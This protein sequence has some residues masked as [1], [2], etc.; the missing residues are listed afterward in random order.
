MAIAVLFGV[1]AILL[2]MGAP[3]AVAMLTASIVDIILFGMPALI[4]AERLT[5]S[6]NSFPLLAI[7]F[8]IL[9]GVI[10]N[11]GGLTQRLLD[12]SRAWVGHF[13]GG[14]A[15]V[16]VLSSIFFSGISGSASADAAAIGSMLIPTMKRE[17]YSS[18]FA[19]GV[20]AASATI[21]PIIP[22]SIVLV[23]Y[24]SMTNLSIG[25]LFLGGI[26][27]GLMIGIGL[28]LVVAVMARRHGYPRSERLSY[29]QRLAVTMRAVPALLAP[30]IIVGGILGGLYTATEAGVIACLYALVVGLV[31]Y[32]ELR[33]RDLGSLLIDAAEQ[34]AIPVFV[35]AS[36]SIFGWLLTIHGFGRMVIGFMDVLDLGPLG[37]L[38]FL[39]VVLTIIGLFVEGLAALI[40]FVPL[41][42]PLI[43]AF[44]LDSIHVALIMV[45]TILIGTV[46]PPVG[47]QLYIAAT[48]GRCPI[49]QVVIWPFVGVML[50]VVVAIVLFP[51]LVT[52]L[53]RI[54]GLA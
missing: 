47:L 28:M 37:V 14:T 11:R 29:R 26:V 7:P 36:A 20:T 44:G 16:N 9:A 23:I 33:P 13:R 34:T 39:V 12:M 17:G 6:V 53:P 15:Q 45:I 51:A 35:L 10:M 52:L 40:I 4:A 21:G 50:L 41:V 27:P 2:L 22:P 38:F 32:R 31:L 1:F 3:V 46:T 24:G 49:N 54:A 42:M 19:V 25:A 8:F 18:G 48:I 43:P 5:S 30:V